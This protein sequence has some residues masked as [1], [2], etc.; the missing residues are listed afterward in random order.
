VLIS[1]ASFIE[2]DEYVYSLRLGESFNSVRGKIN[3]N[4]STENADGF[5]MVSLKLI[6]GAP[7]YTDQT[8]LI[9]YKEK[10]SGVIFT[11]NPRITDFDSYEERNKFL[12]N[13]YNVLTEKIDKKYKMQR[14]SDRFVQCPGR[15]FYD[16]ETCKA[17]AV[18]SDK[19]KFFQMSYSDGEINQYIIHKKQ[20]KSTSEFFNK[21][22]LSIYGEHIN[23]L[24]AWEKSN[25]S[26]DVVEQNDSTDYDLATIEIQFSDIP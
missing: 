21:V 24:K 3:F 13:S 12:I 7:R 1:F 17:K 19:H 23:G 8:T 18:F 2:A 20:F 15:A 5:S 6:P 10:L 11:I 22:L 14:D 26:G 9:F 25:K 16:F 4:F